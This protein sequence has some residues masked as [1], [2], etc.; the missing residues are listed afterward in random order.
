MKIYLASSWK[1]KDVVND[2]A[3]ILRCH[4][5]E[6]DS[7]CQ[8]TEERFSF[9]FSEIEGH[10]NMTAIEFLEHEKSQKAFNEDK[11]WL[12]WADIVIMVKP[13]GNSAHLEAG[14]AKGQGKKLYIY[15][16]F[17][18]GDFDVMYG[19]ADGM[20]KWTDLDKLI[21]ELNEFPV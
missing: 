21:F 18:K 2:L 4:E 20:F 8:E 16:E 14:Y 11:K 6:V 19:F 5:F 12:D 13:C 10:E 15:G 7:F 1:N 17:E 3:G 9:H